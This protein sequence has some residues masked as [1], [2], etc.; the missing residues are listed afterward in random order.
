MVLR[1][2][3]ILSVAYTIARVTFIIS[4]YIFFFS[5]GMLDAQEEY[6]Q[7]FMHN[8]QRGGVTRSRNVFNLQ[9]SRTNK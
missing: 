6:S 8:G 2:F 1:R 7:V 3:K 4:K 9:S 5:G